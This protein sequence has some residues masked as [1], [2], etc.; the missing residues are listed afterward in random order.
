MTCWHGHVPHM[1]DDQM[2]QAVHAYLHAFEARW[3]Q[4]PWAPRLE[5]EK[6]RPPSRQSRPALPQATAADKLEAIDVEFVRVR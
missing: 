1:N 2:A 5:P 3:Q 6:E 4:Q